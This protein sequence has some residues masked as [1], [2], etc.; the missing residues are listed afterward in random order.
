MV[1]A[2]RSMD[3]YCE[4]NLGSHVFRRSEGSRN[5]YKV[6]KV[7]IFDGFE[8]VVHTHIVLLGCDLVVFMEE[9]KCYPST[10]HLSV[11]NSHVI[12]NMY[13]VVNYDVAM[14]LEI[15]EQKRVE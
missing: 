12:E 10:G 1:T 15:G 14:F 3:E 4:T 2:V 8:F 9:N 6:I 11:V 13:R 5:I 7:I